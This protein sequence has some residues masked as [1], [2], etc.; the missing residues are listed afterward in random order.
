MTSMLVRIILLVSF[1]APA[2]GALSNQCERAFCVCSPALFPGAPVEEVVQRW[3]E[4]ASRVVLGRVVRVD[5]L[6]IPPFVQSGIPGAAT[7]ALAAR[8]AVSLVWKGVRADTLTVVFGMTGAWST[9]QVSLAAGKTYVIFAVRD[10]DDVLRIR[11]CTGTEFQS[12]AQSTI[13]ALGPGQEP[14]Q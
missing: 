10:G 12:E 4:Q 2:Y 9:C 3:R 6:P 14:A 5:T 7:G 13:A 1:A 11:R 8:V